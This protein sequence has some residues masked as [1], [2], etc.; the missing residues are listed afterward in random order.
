MV[1]DAVKGGTLKAS[2]KPDEADAFII[3]VPTY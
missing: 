2:E 3:C 1:N